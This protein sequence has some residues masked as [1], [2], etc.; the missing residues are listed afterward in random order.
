MFLINPN[1]GDLIVK[2]YIFRA[3]FVIFLS[4]FLFTGNA[5]LSSPMVHAPDDPGIVKQ[6]P[7]QIVPEDIVSAVEHKLAV[8]GRRP[9]GHLSHGERER[10]KQ[11]IRKTVLEILQ[12]RGLFPAKQKISRTAAIIRFEP[13]E[14]IPVTGRTI[15]SEFDQPIV[16]DD[17]INIF[18]NYNPLIFEPPIDGRFR[19][20]D[21]STLE[22][23]PEGEL[24]AAT[25]YTVSTARLITGA[26]GQFDIKTASYSFH[27][28]RPKLLSVRQSN[29]M[30]GKILFELTFNCPVD[31]THLARKLTV[32]DENRREATFELS[33]P[34][35]SKSIRILL[36][37]RH[38]QKLLFD[39]SP[40][41]RSEQGNLSSNTNY[42]STLHVSRDL[43]ITS[44]YAFSPGSA[45]PYFNLY[46]DDDLQEQDFSPFL[47][48][49][50]ETRFSVEYHT[51]YLRVR[52][53]F[54]PRKT[55]TFTVKKGLKGKDNRNLEKDVVRVVHFPGLAPD[56][57]FISG[58]RIYHAA[59]S[60]LVIPLESVESRTVEVQIE[61]IYN[62]NVVHFINQYSPRRRRNPA[63]MGFAVAG[64]KLSLDG[65]ILSWKKLSVDLK[66]IPGGA[67]P[68]ISVIT[69]WSPEKS[70]K[71]R[72]KLVCI[73][74]IG[75]WASRTNDELLVWANSI[76]NCKPMPGCE[77]N[78]YT[79]TNQ[80]L[81][82]GITN[83][84]GV[85]LFKNCQF[86]DDTRK[87]FLVTATLKDDLSYLD[88]D[89]GALS[90]TDFD[91][92][93]LS[94]TRRGYEAYLYTERGVYRPG[95]TVY[96]RGIVRG[97]DVSLPGEFPVTFEIIRPD[98]KRLRSLQTTISDLG[99][100]QAEF[101]LPADTLT[102][103]YRLKLFVPAQDEAVGSLQFQVEDFM[104]DRMKADIIVSPEIR[105]KTGDTVTG[106]V[107]GKHLYGK[108]AA[109]RR[110]TAVC[111]LRKDTFSHA[112]W[113]GYSFGQPG[114]ED[115]KPITIELGEQTTDE[116]GQ[117]V[118]NFVI[119]AD[120]KPGYPILATI[121]GTIR[122]PG[123]RAVTARRTIAVDPYS[124]YCG[125]KQVRPKEA[126]T[127]D[128]RL[129]F[130]C[131]A[132]LPDGAPAA[133]I[134]IL[135]YTIGKLYWNSILKMGAD[136]RY[137]YVSNQEEVTVADGTV[138]LTGGMGQF[139][140]T[141]EPWETYRINVSH[142]P[143]GPR[144]GL[145]F[146]TSDVISSTWAM[147]RPDRLEITT[148]KKRYREDDIAWITVRSPFARGRMLV[149]VQRDRIYSYKLV[150]ISSRKTRVPIPVRKEYAPN[151]YITA[152]IVRPADKADSLD[153][154]RAFGIV[155]LNV[156]CSRKRLAVSLTAD[157]KV[158]P[159]EL[160]TVSVD[161]T[162]GNTDR[163]VVELSLAAVD[164]GIL[165][166]TQFD[167]PSPWDFFYG[168]RRLQAATSDLYSL[169]FPE[170]RVGSGSTDSEPGGDKEADERRKKLLAPIAVKRVKSIVIFH[171]PIRTDRRGR[172][173]IELKIPNLTGALRLM[174]V[175]VG[176]D[177]FGYAEQSVLVK[178]D[179]VLEASMPRFLS[180]GD[181][182]R[183]PVSLLNDT[184]KQGTAGL[185]ITTEGPVSIAVNEN[186]SDGPDLHNSILRNLHLGP[187]EESRNTFIF[188]A[189]N[190]AGTAK[191]T[192]KA[193]LGDEQTEKAVEL[194]VRPPAP[195]ISTT[196][197]GTVS[198]GKT[199]TIFFPPLMMPET[200]TATL[201]CATS[202]ALNLG[203]SLR[204]LVRYPHGCVE[205]TS[206]RVFPLLYMKDI[207]ALVEPDLLS[208]PG[209]VDRMV[210]AGIYRIL[211]MQTYK[212]GLAMWPGDTDIYPWGTVYGANCLVEAEKAGYQVPF[213]EKEALIS[214]LEEEVADTGSRPDPEHD[215]LAF[216]AYACYV[217]A[218]DGDP[219]LDKITAL[220]EY[221]QLPAYSRF[222][223]AAACYLAGEQAMAREIIGDSLPLLDTN[224]SRDTGGV[225][226][227]KARELAIL[228]NTFLQVD[229]GSP[230]I[231]PLVRKLN[232]HLDKGRY[233]TTQEN[234][235]AL[236]A[237]GRYARSMKQVETS[238]TGTCLLNGTLIGKFTH[239][240]GFF[241]T[242]DEAAGKTVTLSIAGKGTLYYYWV[243]EGVPL[244][245]R[246][247]E[248]DSGLTVRRTFKTA[249]G[250]LIDPLTFKQGDTAVAEYRIRTGSA[251]QNVV[252]SDPLPGGL[253]IEN[254]R[255][256]SRETIEWIGEDS[257]TPD[258]MDIRDDRLIL[259]LDIN[260]TGEIYYRYLVRAVTAGRFRLPA[261]SASCMYD[262]GIRS[263]TGQGIVSIKE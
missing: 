23:L 40:G 162:G 112:D 14:E 52:G 143:D 43:N 216:T 256:A 181:T 70:W 116:Q 74:D 147:E 226:D 18:L 196:G 242:F 67:L 42:T 69:A 185:R 172:A 190:T 65:S 102:G 215:D 123:G 32:R 62:N 248:E 148:D 254:P 73:T 179:L 94:T 146:S 106:T 218:L 239:H 225:L 259:F 140:F 217:L 195:L 232:S 109:G 22:F 222:Q 31:P 160:L 263:V 144:S 192:F 4:F 169:I 142:G 82:H 186:R 55:Y 17:E 124:S 71:R 212:G 72:K 134:G 174:V 251:I 79:K 139:S 53:D 93:G 240:D 233:L 213:T 136:G 26:E 95:D 37:A 92:D 126:H 10:F 103:H 238:L 58:D 27:T 165:Q 262:P 243:L 51:Y 164:E 253:E 5:L 145:E 105:C 200:C 118:F 25:T 59:D 219:P 45:Q 39:I 1:K 245:G 211:S 49:E 193:V 21:P 75:L 244:S 15:I 221:D 96:V 175:A 68:G 189:L 115:F 149:L 133:D 11:L 128:D 220:L 191:I 229:P 111:T 246:V 86:D 156:N 228:L 121:S 177:A 30:E 138:E 122:E 56:V 97:P 137:H 99:T 250:A 223:L 198:A 152:T 151:V 66:K 34:L 182:F 127:R 135:E 80:L 154:Y 131:A 180:T 125:I 150:N 210:Q 168:K 16:T 91:V 197:S 249:A 231:L 227:S 114:D 184:A 107:T 46:F 260:T 176:K 132:V 258:H 236:L 48:S 203:E 41:L 100:C 234:A 20:I 104:P 47:S 155:P 157:K 87:P 163:G 247:D 12:E 173:D 19:F 205:Q 117:A 252:I 214:Y 171:S 187:G 204:Y 209:D 2:K 83:G 77:V 199:A 6:A 257:L 120:L 81:F 108:P 261:L 76:S 101:I 158:K 241:K 84:D 206:S 44:L 161:V 237:L 141:P 33:S 63:N 88:L 110:V 113:S 29:V 170:Y 178:P 230:S 98:G 3:V 207:A 183:V 28:P 224:R 166:L 129:F 9:T 89:R 13:R 54:E 78:V 235:F 60:N 38:G 201:H 188:Q 50:P 208:D 36:K 167:T 255:I 153:N 85:A 8:P 57:R 7:K 61:H 194:M 159:G 202:P 119:P 35:V 64:K 24:P 130:N 90:H